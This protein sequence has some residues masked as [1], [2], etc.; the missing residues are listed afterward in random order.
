MKQAQLAEC[1]ARI[2]RALRL[3]PEAPGRAANPQGGGPGW[4]AS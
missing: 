1:G 2:V 4:A 3:V